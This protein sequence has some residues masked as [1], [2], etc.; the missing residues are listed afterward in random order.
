MSFLPQGYKEPVKSNYLDFQ[1]GDNTFRVLDSSIVGWEYWTNQMVDGEMKARPVRVK[2]EDAI[3]MADVLEGKYGLQLYYFWAFPVYNFDAQRIQIAC[4]KQKTVRQGMISYV[5][6]KKWGDPK[7][8]NF[9]VTKGKDEGGR[10]VYTTIAEPK[11]EL[12]PAIIERYMNLNLDMQVWMRSE[13]PFMSR[14]V[15]EMTGKEIA[16]SME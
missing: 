15:T 4:I 14:P 9:V 3:P 10:I 13:D 5:N 1:D 6:N 7:E 12:D 11:E 8:Y 16:D 2:D